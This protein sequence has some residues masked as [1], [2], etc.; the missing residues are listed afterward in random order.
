MK[1]II[2]LMSGTSCD[3]LDIACCQFVNNAER[4][5]LQLEHLESI[6]Y[7]PDLRDW[8]RGLTSGKISVAEVAQAHFRLGTLFG[9]WAFDHI[10]RHRL[11]GKV[12]LIV[13]HGQ[14]VFHRPFM[15]RSENEPACTLQIGDGDVIASITGTRVLSDVRVKDMAYGGQGA[16][17]VVWADYV[18]FRS[19]EKNVAMQ[20]IGGIGNVT[21]LPKA[22]GV[23]SVLAFDTGPG[24]VLIDEA[25]RTLFER[26]FDEDGEIS[27]KGTVNRPLFNRMREIE[28]GY[29]AERPPKSTGK[30][31]RYHQQYRE[32]LWKLREE[33]GC[34]PHDF[35]RTLVALTAWSIGESYRRY[36]G[37]V[38]RVILT[39]G[40]ALNPTLV[41]EIIAELPG[42]EIR[43]LD[44]DWTA[45]KEA[46]AF[47][48]I[49][50][51]YLNGHPANV[52]SATGARKAVTLGKLSLPE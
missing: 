40:G 13:S 10:R 52:P 6:E 30:E 11:E 29:V 43:K 14:T 19:K 47:A 1:R 48:V 27:A 5:E 50:N 23:E 51:E 12:D 9:D 16:P 34:S 24:N 22:G 28:E 41:A 7:P 39:G 42:T 38:E 20:N 36:L 8:I 44:D 45:F 15:G 35:V 26:K 32:R 33:F 31:I 46:I 21:F 17:M 4:T 25:C 37:E 49:G 3:G 2:G 18:L